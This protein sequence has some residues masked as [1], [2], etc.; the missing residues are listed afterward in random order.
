MWSWTLVHAAGAPCGR[1][2]APPGSTVPA[3]PVSTEYPITLAAEDGLCVDTATMTA[4]VPPRGPGTP[5]R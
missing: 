4:V 2:H 5:V 1:R 3:H